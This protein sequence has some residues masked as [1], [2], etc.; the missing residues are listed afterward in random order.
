[1][2]TLRPYIVIASIYSLAVT[3]TDN[4]VAYPLPAPCRPNYRML[5]DA[6]AHFHPVAIVKLN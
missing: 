1:M 2:L 3:M 6:V 5:K 4:C